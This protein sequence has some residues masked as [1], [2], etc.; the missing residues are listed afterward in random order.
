MTPPFGKRVPLT[1]SPRNKFYVRSCVRARFSEVLILAPAVGFTLATGEN[2]STRPKKHRRASHPANARALPPPGHA[3]WEWNPDHHAGSAKTAGADRGLSEGARA[4]P[5]T[6]PRGSS[7][8]LPPVSSPSVRIAEAP[9]RLAGLKT[10]ADQQRRRP[11]HQ[12]PALVCAQWRARKQ[13]HQSRLLR[14]LLREQPTDTPK[15]LNRQAIFDDPLP[16]I[17]ASIFAA[18]RH[19]L[20][21]VLGSARPAE[22]EFSAR[23]RLQWPKS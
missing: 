4:A 6:I 8:H 14:A 23:G 5:R 15:T 3:G 12:L 22:G 21:T 16:S 20:A 18:P 11:R 1:A 7:N 13:P 9:T 17:F 2:A 19:L 10:A